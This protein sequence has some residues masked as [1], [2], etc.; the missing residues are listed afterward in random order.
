MQSLIFPR[1]SGVVPSKYISSISIVL[2]N[3]PV[4]CVQILPEIRVSDGKI[5][6]PSLW[7]DLNVPETV[8]ITFRTFVHR[9]KDTTSMSIDI[10]I[11]VR[12]IKILVKMHV[13]QLVYRILP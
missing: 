4:I 1:F 12:S 8:S 9:Y 6:V 3:S 7:N 2:I 10:K 5:V 11:Y 13:A